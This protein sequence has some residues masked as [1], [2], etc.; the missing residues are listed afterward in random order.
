[1]VGCVGEP[2]GS[3]VGFSGYANPAQF[4][5]RAIGVVGGESF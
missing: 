1:M 4:T 3:P 2:Q 5:T